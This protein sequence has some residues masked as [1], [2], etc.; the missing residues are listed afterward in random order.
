MGFDSPY[1]T[2][3]KNRINLRQI[4]F[5]ERGSRL[6]VF[7][8]DHHL[9]IRLAERWLKRDQKLA[10]YRDRPPIIDNWTFIDENG[11]PLEFELVTFPH[12]ID[13]LT[14]IGPFSLAFLDTESLLISLP[15]AVCGLEFRANLDKAQVDRRGGILRLTG[16]IRRNVAYTSNARILLDEKT[17]L[18]A[19]SQ[20]VHLMVDASDG[21]KALLLNITPTPGF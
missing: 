18:G 10:A 15:A 13:C 3:L 6:L 17:T 16:D 4:P 11:Q 14:R 7:H 20:R 2:L 19:E 1:L 12:R 8:S 9:S 21:G 5:S